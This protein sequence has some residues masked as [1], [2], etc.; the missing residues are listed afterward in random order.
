MA[1][2]VKLA[3]FPLRGRAELIRLILEA[4]GISYQE[5]LVA[6]DKWGPK[7]DSMPFR[8]LPVL[9]WDGEVIGQSL[10]IARFVAK[11]AGL[12]GNT[13]IEQA[14]AD[15]IVDA[16]SDIAPKLFEIKNKD[17]SSKPAAVQGFVD[18]NLTTILSISENLLKNRG[19]K[20][21]TGNKLSYGDIAIFNLIDLFL[22]K[23]VMTGFGFGHVLEAINKLIKN[24][25]L[26]YG[27]YNT[28]KNQPKIAEYL[29]K[30]PSYPF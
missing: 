19:G 12:A 15:A 2:S 6:S 18:N 27:V 22:T 8:S 26:T 13:D 21:I 4:K 7:K 28:V 29:T 24:H 3:Y 17:E 5:E 14:R 25:P 30:R 11:K 1:P 16:V 9:H 23:E 20:F 10:T